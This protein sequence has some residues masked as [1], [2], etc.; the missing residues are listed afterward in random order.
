[1]VAR[2]SDYTPIMLNKRVFS[3]ER[4]NRS[5]PLVRR[6]VED[7]R[8]AWGRAGDYQEQFEELEEHGDWQLAEQT[9]VALSRARQEYREFCRELEQ[10][11]CYVSAERAG[12]VGFPAIVGGR[13]V[14]LCWRLGESKISRWHDA[15]KEPSERSSAGELDRA[16]KQ[17]YYA[18]EGS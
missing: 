13:W 3:L 12:A 6:I 17:C 11:G 8:Q 10:L 15:G 1:M 14:V 4:A 2:I 7:I 16:N 9:I 18:N 5:L